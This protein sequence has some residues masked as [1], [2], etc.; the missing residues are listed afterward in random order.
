[1]RSKTTKI[2]ERKADETGCQ[3]RDGDDELIAGTMKRSEL[4]S[5]AKQSVRYKGHEQKP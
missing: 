5:E 2:V 1:M 4:T 3:R